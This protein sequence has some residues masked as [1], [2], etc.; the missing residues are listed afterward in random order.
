MPASDVT[1][2]AVFAEHEFG[3]WTANGDDTHTGTCSCGATETG[4]CD[5]KNGTC[6][7]CSYVD[8]AITTQP[9]NA[10]VK[11]GETATFT[12]AAAGDNLSYQWQYSTNGSI[13]S[14]IENETNTSYTIPDTTLGMS[15]NQYRCVVSNGEGDSAE[16]NPATLTVRGT[17]AAPAAPTVS[18]TT[19]PT[20]TSITLEP[21]S[22]GVNGV[23]Y[24]C[25]EGT[26]GG[27]P[28]D[29]Q[30]STTFD[31][32]LTAATPYTFYARYKGNSGYDQSPPSTGTTIYTAYA[33]PGDGEGYTINYTSEQ[34][35]AAENYQVSLNGTDW[36]SGPITITPGGS[37]QVRHAAATGGPPASAPI[38]V[39]V[40]NRPAKPSQQ[41]N[42][43]TEQ[44]TVA[45]G[46]EYKIGDNGAWTAVTVNTDVTVA[47]GETIHI[48]VA[49][50]DSAFKSDE[51]SV[52]APGQAVQPE[53]PGINYETEALTGDL[54]GL[55]WGVAASG[56]SVPSTWTACTSN[57]SL[58]D[59]LNWTG[60]KMTVYFRT[61]ATTG[62]GGQYASTHVSLTIP[63]R[64]G[65]PDLSIDNEAESVT[66][67][68]GYRYNTSSYDYAADGWEDGDGSPVTVAPGSAIYI[69][70]AAVT[71][72]GDAAF[73]STV[74]TLAAPARAEKPSVSINYTAETVS[75]TTA[76]EWGVAASG[77]SVPTSW[78][79]CTEAM[80]V[81]AFGW[82]GSAEV[83]AYFRTAATDAL[84]AS[85][86]TEALTIKAR[87]AAPTGVSGGTNRIYGLT[88]AMEYL[89]PASGEEPA[90][91]QPV[92]E[93]KL[94]NGALSG[95][96]AG[97]YQVRYAATDSD[98]ASQP[99]DAFR[100]YNPSAPSRPAT[101][102]TVTIPI[103]GEENTIYEEAT[104]QGNTA[105][106]ES[107]DLGGLEDV[108]GGHVA[109]GTVTID[110]SAV[111]AEVDTV[112]IPTNAVQQIAAA[113]GDPENDAESLEIILSNGTSIAFDAAALGEIAVQAGGVDISISIQ[114][115]EGSGAQVSVVGSRPAYDINV[116]SGGQHITDMG[117]NI[118]VKA[119]YELRAGER[120]SGLVVY[121]V[122]DHG[123]RER[124]VTHYDSA[125]RQV[126]WETGHLSLYMIGYDEEQAAACPRDETCPLAK[127]TDLNVNAWYHDGI[128]YCVEH[129]LMN[130]TSATTFEPDTTTSRAMI[131]VILWRQAGSPIAE[132]Y[133]DFS[134]VAEGAWYTQAVRWASSAGVVGGYPNGTF[135]PNDPITREQMAAML[136]RYAQYQG[137]GTATLEENLAGFTDADKISG[138]AVQPMNWAVG[139]GVMGG[140]GDGTLGPQGNATRA[141][142]AAMLQRFCEA[143]I[144]SEE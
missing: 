141:Q 16:S 102:T 92:P 4:N 96:S 20:D 23:E 48:R 75:T 11:D 100:V 127:F 71:S 91:W 114:T 42:N 120:A 40:D 95:L 122:D 138:Y 8:V 134:D 24:G 52:T 33:K 72:E 135:G 110:F 125:T 130:G 123:S 118:T 90:V 64:P 58:K 79:A 112:Q 97:M 47:P 136:Y 137:M 104:I 117:G 108:I 128:H 111:D 81:T 106:I 31:S 35:T 49:A 66:I 129:G 54:S 103:S 62:T 12:V 76:L 38:T 78:T 119:P 14:D 107:I 27:T 22:G 37:F 116:T 6:S 2:K 132:E 34:V 1:V 83:T 121:Y 19:P 39:N 41:L 101:P 28:T 144:D 126:V 32:G 98:F 26:T 80:N 30:D 55:E 143:Y 74:Q 3:N 61:K 67:P 9:E 139:Q 94:Q 44:I 88:A 18:T 77:Q 86:P 113:V 70:K 21:I 85:D 43:T 124:C 59:D 17:Q 133:T 131:A 5:F 60:S 99:T 87:P 142:A 29:W 93:D 105:T 53:V 84:Y 140:Y 63:A 51:H 36:S 45:A 68:E 13:W 109:T 65:A 73:K 57:M 69:Y 56:Q 89:P 25:V 82:D 10:S 115:S 50:T 46:Q 15:G 7:V